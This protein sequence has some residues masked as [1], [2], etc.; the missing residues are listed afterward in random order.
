LTARQG[1][2]ITS[3][4]IIGTPEH[5]QIL[6]ARFGAAIVDMETAVLARV[7]S[8]MGIPLGCVRAVSD[9]ARDDFLAFL[10]GDPSAGALRRAVQAAAARGWLRRYRRW[11]DQ[12]QEARRSLCR[13]LAS[14]LDREHREGGAPG[15][16]RE[17]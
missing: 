5:K 12:S 9:D 3:W 2:A 16:Q 17:A 4:S 10:S 13:V 7:A 15:A 1:S 11:R 6:F 8:S 14:Y